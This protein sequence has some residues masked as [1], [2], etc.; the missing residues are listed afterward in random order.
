MDKDKNFNMPAD[1]A[2]IFIRKGGMY[3]NASGD[4]IKIAFKVDT[5]DHALQEQTGRNYEELSDAVIQEVVSGIHKDKRWDCLLYEWNGVEF[6][7][8]NPNKQDWFNCE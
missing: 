5:P 3:R 4:G 6:E 8:V 2:D 7:Q 1:R